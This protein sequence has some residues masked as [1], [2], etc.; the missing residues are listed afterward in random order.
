M[1]A[2]KT[3][4]EFLLE[5]L[6]QEIAQ[7]RASALRNRI[8]NARFRQLKDLDAFNFNESA[9]DEAAIRA[10]HEGDSLSNKQNIIFMSGS[11]TSKSHLA[12]S[13]GLRGCIKI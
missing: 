6:E 7:R 4:E 1:K 12:A 9:V 8:K 11:G 2:K 3:H 5:L 13:I 10:L